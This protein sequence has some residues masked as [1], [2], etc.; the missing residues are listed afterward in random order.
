SQAN[1]LRSALTSIWARAK[2]VSLKKGQRFTQA[3]IVKSQDYLRAHLRDSG[4]LTSTV[5]LDP[6]EYR[7]ETNRADLTLQVEPRTMVSVQIVGAHIWKRT[8]KRLLPIYEEN[9]IDA[10]L[11]DEGG[12]N[13]VS[14]FQAKGFFDTSVK[15]QLEMGGE[16]IR[17]IYTIQKDG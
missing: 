9:L 5:R 14:Y 16:K 4:R 8:R 13:L 2:G 12:R 3:R 15:P 10:E 6:P 11:V 1:E 17:V 7:P